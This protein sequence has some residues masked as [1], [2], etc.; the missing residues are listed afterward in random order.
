MA[1]HRDGEFRSFKLYGLDKEDL[2]Q[3]LKKAV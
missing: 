3:V 1:K 2:I